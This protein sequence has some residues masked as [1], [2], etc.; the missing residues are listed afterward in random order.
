L[1]IPVEDEI[2]L[3]PGS[4]CE[5]VHHAYQVH[6][7]IG[8]VAKAEE[9]NILPGYFRKVCRI[10]PSQLMSNRLIFLSYSSSGWVLHRYLLIY[11]HTCHGLRGIRIYRG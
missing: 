9:S 6:L 2:H 11:R 5:L 3:V 1:L 10:W 7:L 8:E 4:F